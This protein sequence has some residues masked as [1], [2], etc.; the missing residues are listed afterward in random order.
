MTSEIIHERLIEGLRQFFLQNKKTDA[1]V[2]LSGG[3]DSAVVAALAVE[4][5]GKEHVTGVLMPSQY[6]TL[7]SVAD[8]VML[9]ENLDITHY[10]IPIESIYH[11][12]IKELAPVFGS[13]KKMDVTEENLQA[14]I[15]ATLLMAVSNKYDSLVLNTSNK[16]ELAMGYGTLYGDLI[17]ALM[18][19][20]DLYKTQVYDT[21]RCLNHSRH[22]VPL[23]TLHKE[24]SAELRPGQK[25][26]DTLPPYPVLDPIL[27]ALIDEQLSPD[28]A[29]QK[30]FDPTTVGRVVRQMER[31]AF[32]G[33]QLPLL[34]KIGDRPLLGS[35]K[36]FVC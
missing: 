4:A 7:H 15:R 33:H 27:H 14:R 2:G 18:V 31:V 25:D 9:A 23:N 11:T 21:A 12:F 5:L 34:L 30:G 17:G 24:P 32:K 1:V 35:E 26:R 36:W 20:G 22:V 13:R 3:I 28:E 10:L 16:S 8:A 19:I 29:I 6:S